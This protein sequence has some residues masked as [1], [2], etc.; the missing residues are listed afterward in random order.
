MTIMAIILGLSCLALFLLALRIRFY[1]NELAKVKV[2]N[3]QLLIQ[4]IDIDTAYS[5][6]NQSVE[7]DKQA[8]SKTLHDEV[9]NS[10]ASIKLMVD[11]L[12]RNRYGDDFDM[13]LSMQKEL[14]LSL[15]TVRNISKDAYPPSLKEHGLGF[16]IGELCDRLSN[17][18][19]TKIIFEENMG[20]IRLQAN[21]ELLLYRAVQEL[22][23]NAIKHS[24]AWYVY[25]TITCLEND[26]VITVEDNG[27]GYGPWKKDKGGMGLK[28]IQSSLKTIN[29]SVFLDRERL[30]FKVQIKHPIYNGAYQSVHSR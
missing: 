11:A 12:G 25:V 18:K 23:G 24:L 7:K 1:K 30:G 26:L 14:T 19:L 9:G 20:S 8:F 16:A 5:L 29:T 3:R 22:I 28:S 13:L 2:Q 27:V 15:H 4:K 17:P 21:K 10:L 6:L